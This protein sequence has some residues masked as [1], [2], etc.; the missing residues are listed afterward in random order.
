MI[1]AIEV[2]LAGKLVMAI[3]SIILAGINWNVLRDKIMMGFEWASGE[4]GW[5]QVVAR[6]VW[7]WQS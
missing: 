4:I 7:R 1:L 3:K 6:M 2:N 5:K